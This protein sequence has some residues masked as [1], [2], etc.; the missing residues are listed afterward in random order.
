M[1]LSKIIGICVF[2]ILSPF[3]YNLFI[4][5]LFVMTEHIYYKENEK[6]LKNEH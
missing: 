5:L 2:S 1:S 6:I 4:L 3:L